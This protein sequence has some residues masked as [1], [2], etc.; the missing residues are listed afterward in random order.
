MVLAWV[1]T[2]P[3]AAAVG[4]LAAVVAEQGTAGIVVVLVAAVAVATAIYAVSRRNP[5]HA[6][7]VNDHPTTTVMPPTQASAA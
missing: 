2:L 6:A 7:N 1:F 3:A 4:G 5:V